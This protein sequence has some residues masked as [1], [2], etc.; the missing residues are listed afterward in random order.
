MWFI[1]TIYSFFNAVSTA[2]Q[3]SA[4]T[5][6]VAVLAGET[7]SAAVA[8][9]MA[10][11]NPSLINAIRDR[12]IRNITDDPESEQNIREFVQSE[13]AEETAA[14]YGV[15]V[16]QVREFLDA[17]R[18]ELTDDGRNLAEKIK[19]KTEQYEDQLTVDIPGQYICPITLCIMK[20]PVSVVTNVN[21]QQVKHHFDRDAVENHIN[22][23]ANPTNPL[24]RKP[25]QKIENAE[26]LQQQIHEFLNNPENYQPQ[27]SHSN[28]VS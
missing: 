28:R 26:E 14:Y 11:I 20:D 15:E 22:I 5:S 3:C 9:Y 7:T 19:Q 16:Q 27:V 4:E 6:A 10:G 2:S 13:L 23:R 12:L 24:N 25:I 17:V 18:G 1:D 21:G 8:D